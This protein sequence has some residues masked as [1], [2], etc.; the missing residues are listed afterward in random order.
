M[1]RISLIAS[2]CFF[3]LITHAQTYTPVQWDSLKRNGQLN[4]DPACV[5]S[6][7]RTVQ[8]TMA[9][10]L[11]YPYIPPT[12][13]S[14]TCQCWQQRDANWNIVPIT[15]G[16]PP[17]YRNDDGSTG[18]INLP[19]N[20]CL[21]GQTWNQVYINNN[22]NISFGAPYGTFTASG[23]PNNQFV[24]VAPFWSDVDTRNTASGLP[25][26]IIT[27]TY[28][29]VQWDSVGYYSN[30]ADKLNSFQLIITDGSD[31][32][33][34]SGNVSFCYEDMQWTTGD[35]SGG[36]GGFQGSDAIVGANLGDGVNYIQFGGFNQ[37]GGTYNGPQ[38]P[39]S[40]ID[41]LDYQTFIFDACT[42]SNNIPPT[43]TGLNACDTL[44]ICEGDTLPLNLTFFSPEAGQVTTIT[45]DTTGTT[46]YFEASNTP[47]NTAALVAY[48]LGSAANNG[49]N[50]I[51]IY[52]TDNGVPTATT[53]IPIVVQVLPA[54]VV[55]A[56][57]DTTICAGASVNLNASGASTYTWTPPGTLN[58]ANIANPVATPTATTTYTVSGSN[59]TC[60]DLEFVLVTV[61]VPLADAGQD[62]VI[63]T[64]QSTQLN[65]TGGVSYSWSPA[66]GL[67]NPGIPN[68]VAN[69]TVTTTYTVTVTDALGCSTIDVVTV[70]VNPAPNASF[71]FSPA[72]VFIDSLY[73]FIDGSTSANQ[74]LWTFGD[75]DSAT[76]QNTAHSYSTAG[77]YVVCLVV[78]SANG[79]SDTTCSTV[80]VQPHDIEIPNVFTPNGDNINDLL[81][82]ENLEF[83][84][85]SRL[86]VY[87]R[88]GVLVY[89][90]DNYL[91]D[92]NGKRMGNGGDCADGTYYFILYGPN[93]KEPVTGFI[94][95]IRG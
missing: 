21:Y 10:Q 77:S 6:P 45:V 34:P 87:D 44:T 53:T 58:N 38:G 1:K 51:T 3:A 49:Y 75:G 19:F 95:L 63:C 54:P 93:L 17:E 88:W 18:V 8:D 76:T 20:F 14:T 2:V 90:A 73:T 23:F 91:N 24:M 62:V 71:S 52:A 89:E 80:E 12:P 25:W 50:N 68:P 22:G 92:W 37:P 69:P 72:I 30:Y 65:A 94:T 33:V 78:T 83:F 7:L 64:G 43:I 26:Y 39:N 42:Q 9:Y 41:W 31:P 55:T 36:I 46:G 16:T 28:M 85:G 74:W 40:G 48:F 84:P 32:I 47:G 15:I 56:S 13:A 59:G 60:D 70:T 67:S 5:A 86:E 79:C 82:F 35:A 11:V 66:T 27:P 81:V 57:S 61:Q 29:I 4:D